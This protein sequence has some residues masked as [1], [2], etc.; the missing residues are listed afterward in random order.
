MPLFNS[1]GNMEVAPLLYTLTP[2]TANS[3][4]GPYGVF[5]GP[6]DLERLPRH[7]SKGSLVAIRPHPAGK[8]RD[9]EQLINDAAD[10]ITNAP[11]VL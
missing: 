7:L 6:V 2:T 3:F 1:R 11:L 5:Q 4:D 8:W 10:R 9:V